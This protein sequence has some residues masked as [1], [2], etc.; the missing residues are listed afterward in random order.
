MRISQARLTA[1]LDRFARIDLP[2]HQQIF[3][4][5]QRMTARQLVEAVERSTCA[6]AAGRRS[7]SAASCGQSWT[8]PSPAG[9][10]R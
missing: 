6:A 5:M 7:P 1:G 10:R 3:G 4:P 2:T 8:R 9:A